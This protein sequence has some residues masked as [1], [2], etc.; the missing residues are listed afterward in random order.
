M[1]NTREMPLE[2]RLSAYIDGQL[3]EDEAREL[4]ALV[5]TDP[6]ARELLAVL[7]AGS[8]FGTQAFDEML[9]EPVPLSL[10]RAIKDTAS[11]PEAPVRQ[12]ANS[13]IASFFRFIPQAIAASAVLLLAG[14]YSGYFIG[15]KSAA[16]IPME[17]SE[18]SA[19][20]A[21]AGA[22]R[23][24]KTRDIGKFT[25]DAPVAVSL[26]AIAINDVAGVHDVYSK[27]TT[28]LAEVPAA[29]VDTLKSWLSASTGVTF[30]V[31]DLTSDGLNFE[32]GRLV[33][34]DGQPTGALFY[35]SGKGEVVAVYFTKGTATDGQTAQGANQY[36][37]GSKGD[38]AWFVAGPNDASQLKDIAGKASAAL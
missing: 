29:D 23:E 8:Q 14:G 11:K 30:N 36:L 19:L 15:M 28:R 10:V 25:F 16:E 37:S 22:T 38:M 34:V 33:A 31:P 12:A 21:P 4:E 1:E 32:G 27:Q 17:I 26:P 7:N 24:I 20:E 2:V 18:T 6:H 13:N 35:K 9:K 5:A 3:G